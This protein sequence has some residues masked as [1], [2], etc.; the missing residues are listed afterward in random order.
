MS[1]YERDQRIGFSLILCVLMVMSGTVWMVTRATLLSDSVSVLISVPT[2]LLGVIFVFV[3]LVLHHLDCQW[4]QL[5]IG[6]AFV[7]S[8]GLCFCLKWWLIE[9]DG[10]A[11]QWRAVSA[12]VRL[13][14][15]VNECFLGIYPSTLVV[16]WTHPT[17]S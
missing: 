10:Y 3:C 9:A 16:L 2:W 14:V 1:N 12:G 7:M 6:F 11:E 13:L 17:R 8:T 5:Q 4:K 15:D